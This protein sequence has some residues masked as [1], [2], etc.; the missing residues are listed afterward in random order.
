M[1]SGQ[2][3]NEPNLSNGVI[4]QSSGKE[5]MKYFTFSV[6]KMQTLSSEDDKWFM[7]TVTDK[8]YKIAPCLRIKIYAA[9][10]SITF[11]ALA[12]SEQS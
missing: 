6:L 4:V 2:G 7:N 12:R 10:R 3:Q 5:Q 1:F 11:L 8:H 9:H